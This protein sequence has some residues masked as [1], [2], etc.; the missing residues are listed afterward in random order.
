MQIKGH[1]I[2]ALVHQLSQVFERYELRRLIALAFAWGPFQEIAGE[3]VVGTVVRY[4]PYVGHAL[5]VVIR[6]G[7]GVYEDEVLEQARHGEMYVI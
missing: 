1:D 6:A 5:D 3:Q 2:V 4:V 7:L